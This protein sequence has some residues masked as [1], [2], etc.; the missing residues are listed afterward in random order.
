[1]ARKGRAGS[2][3]IGRELKFNFVQAGDGWG[4]DGL[5]ADF[6]MALLKPQALQLFH[7]R[8]DQ[9][10]NGLAALGGEFPAQTNYFLAQR[11]QFAVDPRQFGVALLQVL[12]FPLRFF[13][14]GDDFLQRRA[15]F[16]FERLKQIEPLL[17]LPKADG[18]GFDAVGVAAQGGGQFVPRR[19]GLFMEGE[20]ARAADESRRCKAWSVRPSAPACRNNESSCSP[21]RL[22]A[23]WLN[24][25]S[26][27]ALPARWKSSVNR[28]SSSACNLAAEISWLW[29]RR[30]SSCR[31]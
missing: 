3:A 10:G 20:Q 24:S 5:Q 30:R 18:I 25:R 1:M 16:A 31:A 4:F 19:H 27:V 21:N 9:F 8:L 7:G 23:A 15:V 28:P 14:K 26:R 12:Q 11:L 22:S 17:Q 13:A 2:P 29:K 6:E